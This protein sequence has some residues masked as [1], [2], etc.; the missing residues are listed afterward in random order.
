MSRI[1]RALEKAEKEKQQKTKGEPFYT[2]LEKE[3]FS[4]EDEPI[5]K[6]TYG[7]EGKLYQL[8]REQSPILLADPSSFAAEQFRKLKTHIFLR[9]TNPP[10][11]FLITSSIAGEGKTTAAI[12]LAIAISQELDRTAILVQTDLRK[13]GSN[14]KGQESLRNLSNYL[15]GRIG[16]SEILRNSE[17]GNLLFIP[18]GKPTAKP[19]EMIGSKRMEELFM[20]M[21]SFGKNPYI[22]IDSPPIL[23]TSEPISLSKM[24][25]G[26]ILVVLA[27]ETP[28]GAVRRSVEAIGRQKIIGFIF[29][30]KELMRS[31]TYGDYY[32]T[33]SRKYPYPYPKK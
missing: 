23:S 29:N 31:R 1:Y 18:A 15:E 20:A 13:A 9:F 7:L 17:G 19:A 25:D 21:R 6:S 2:N 33:Y 32:Y 24:V 16:I 14:L 4:K 27:G 22:I 12:N 8:I 26:I 30:Q 5:L 3:M 28:K 10:H 11:F